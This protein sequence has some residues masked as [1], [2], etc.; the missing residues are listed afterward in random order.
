M[1]YTQS[2]EMQVKIDH[3]FDIINNNNNNNN[4]TQIEMFIK[5]YSTTLETNT[6]GV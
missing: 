1:E 3:I 5:K 4:N 2:N 6:D